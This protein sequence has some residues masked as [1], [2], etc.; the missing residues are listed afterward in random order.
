MKT[1]QKTQKDKYTNINDLSKKLKNTH[2]KKKPRLFSSNYN[3]NES[4]Q[5]IL[6]LKEL[7]R[8]LNKLQEGN[9]IRYFKSLETVS[10]PTNS[11]IH[12]D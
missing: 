10:A 2:L 9:I 7:N 3:N 4:K 6:F 8:K 11:P 5:N 12:T 1:N